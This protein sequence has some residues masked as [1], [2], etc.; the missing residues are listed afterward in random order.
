MP[1]FFTTTR[2][3]QFADDRKKALLAFEGQFHPCKGNT[4]GKN[5]VDFVQRYARKEH[6][7]DELP[8]SRKWKAGR[9][10][11]EASSNS[12]EAGTAIATF[13]KTPVKGF[14]DNSRFDSKNSYV[15]GGCY[16]AFYLGHSITGVIT[17]ARVDPLS[18]CVIKIVE[19]TQ[20]AASELY[21]IET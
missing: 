5:G 14:S 17:I 3:Y 13:V 7:L 16:A 9:Q 8:E 19:I 12:I 18:P 10:L 21:V 4:D 20:G 15:P 1:Y 2:S 6:T 11:Q